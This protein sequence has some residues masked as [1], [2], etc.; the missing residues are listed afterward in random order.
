M[1]TD[2][3]HLLYSPNHVMVVLMLNKFKNFDVPKYESE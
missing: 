1:L 2:V 3:K